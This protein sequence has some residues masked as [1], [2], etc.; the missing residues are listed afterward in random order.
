MNSLFTQNYISG[1]TNSV[2]NSIIIL[3]RLTPFPLMLLFEPVPEDALAMTNSSNHS[4]SLTQ[5]NEPVL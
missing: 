1:I 2:T 5:C 3:H 4:C